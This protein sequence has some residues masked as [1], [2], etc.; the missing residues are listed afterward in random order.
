MRRLP[1]C[2]GPLQCSGT[3]PSSPHAPA[4]AFELT[5]VDGG[6]ISL[7]DLKG[8]VVLLNFWATWCPPCR[9]SIPHINK[10]YKTYKTAIDKR[11]FS[12]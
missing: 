4:P 7:A 1:A 8:Q 6:K 10:L 2:A 9:T 11:D 3:G 12:H 5:L